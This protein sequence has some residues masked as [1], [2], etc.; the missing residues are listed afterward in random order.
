MIAA[1]PSPSLKLHRTAAASD[2]LRVAEPRAWP[3]RAL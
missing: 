2:R 1:Q 3:A